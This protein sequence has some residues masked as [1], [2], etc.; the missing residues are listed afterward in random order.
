MRTYSA[1]LCPKCKSFE[2]RP[3]PVRKWVC[4]AGPREEEML[5]DSKNDTSLI[6]PPLACPDFILKG[7][8]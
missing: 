4:K 3:I 5:V 1:F 6:D 7:R 2:F 8:K